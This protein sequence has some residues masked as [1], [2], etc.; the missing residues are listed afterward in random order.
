MN[1]KHFFKKIIKDKITRGAVAGTIAGVVMEIVNYPFSILNLFEIRPIDFS[2]LIVTHHKAHTPLENLTGFINH[3]FFASISG[4]ILSY[5]LAKTNYR[6]PIIK[7]MAVGLGTNINLL[8]LASFFNIKP[9]IE[10]TTTNILLLDA[11]AT[12]VYGLTL[13]LILNYFN[14]KLNLTPE[15]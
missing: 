4:V 3:L 15:T 12:F 6:F 7:G 1:F 9:I 5:I 13:G 14:K 8:I 11:S 10:I 2:Y